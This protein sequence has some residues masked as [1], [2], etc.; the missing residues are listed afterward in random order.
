MFE[1]PEARHDVKAKLAGKSLSMKLETF[2][3][4]LAYAALT[5]EKVQ[6]STLNCIRNFASCISKVL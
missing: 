3:L 2:P 4:V 6:G 1:F 5:V